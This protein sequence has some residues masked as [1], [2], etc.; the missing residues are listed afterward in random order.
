[1]S[2]HNAQS[3][4]HP[5]RVRIGVHTGEVVRQSGDFFG[6]HVNY[7][8]RIADQASGGEILVSELTRAL[9]QGSPEFRFG[10]ERTASLKGFPGSHPIFSL[11]WDPEPGFGVFDGEPPTGF[12]G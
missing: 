3:R 12:G 5:I 1:L 9:V 10:S 4:T 6:R 11:E 7:A 8:S 2:A